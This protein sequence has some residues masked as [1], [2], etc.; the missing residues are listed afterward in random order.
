MQELE[1]Y[2]S[3]QMEQIEK[4]NLQ[5]VLPPQHNENNIHV[6]TECTNKRL[7]SVDLVFMV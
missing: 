2:W 7:R 1:L 5:F 6:S 4:H 3:H